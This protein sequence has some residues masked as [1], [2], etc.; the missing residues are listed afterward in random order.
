MPLTVITLKNSPPSLR[1]DLTK[2]MQEIA[3]GVYVGNFNSKV[4]EELW[5][6]AVD[7]VGTGE[8]TISYA[9]RNEIG[10]NFETHNTNKTV[11]DY[12]GI[13]LVLTPISENN[14]EEVEKKH[15]FSTASKMRNAKKFTARKKNIKQNKEYTV[16][17]VETT[18]LDY[19]NDRIIEIGAVKV[20]DTKEEYTTII[21]YNGKL[22]DTIKRL[23]GIT[24]DEL[25]I[26]KD[27]KE[28]VEE[29]LQFLGDSM[30]IGYNVE[31]D[32][33]FINETLKRNDYPVLKNKVYDI[34]KYVKQEKLFLKNYKLQTV[35]KEYGIN[36]R[37]PHR[38]LGDAKLSLKL[39]NK[40]N[41]FK[42]ILK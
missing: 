24:E 1:G 40:V 13:P 8:A 29:F 27:E 14:K 4:R 15:G 26:G 39:L 42:D 16:I 18:G 37:V 30:I 11:I 21:K 2:W 33:K 23:T 17:D 22:S 9:Y 25:K 20:A 6:R 36:E 12:D 10:Y 28:V 7:S 38:A 31:F 3:V 34:I 32:I 19:K 35:L 5:K 41:K